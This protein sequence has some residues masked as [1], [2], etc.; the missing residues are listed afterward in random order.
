MKNK[1]NW[2][3]TKFVYRNGKL[4]A[5]RDKKEVTVSSRLATNITAEF[6]QKE[7]SNYAKGKLLDLS[8]GNV[9]LYAT[10]KDLVE[11]NF[12][13][14]WQDSMHLNKYLD[15]NADLNKPLELSDNEFD[16]IITSSVL[17][18]IRR[19]ELMMSE[20]ARVLKPKG[21]MLLNVPFYYCIHEEPHDYFRYTEFALQSM[22]EEVGMKVLSLKA[23][24]GAPEIIA[25]IFAK[26]LKVIPLIGKPLVR[27]IHWSTWVFVH[28]GI[29]RKISNK[30]AKKFPL[31]Y[32]VIA[33][34]V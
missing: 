20:M 4:K 29:G 1:E 31:G 32:T 6:Y 17:E 16:V 3:P 8:C 13:V 10:Y 23:T 2:L 30:T 33:E 11:D 21:V 19:P 26:N 14:D 25:D 5:S 15:L 18:H 27:F 34:K 24:G 22:T 12:C 7:L 9:P 28:T